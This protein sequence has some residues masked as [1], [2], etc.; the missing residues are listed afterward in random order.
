MHRTRLLAAAALLVAAVA[1]PVRAGEA[2]AAATAERFQL[3]AHSTLAAGA[4][5]S[6]RR[7]GWAG[8]AYMTHTGERVTVLVSTTYAEADAIG[9]RW[10]N[11]LSSLLHGSELALVR[12]HVAPLPEVEEFCE[13]RV[14]GCYGGN[15]LV[16]IGEPVDDVTAEEVMR[17]EYG[18]HVAANR[19]NPPWAA[20]DWG[21][22]RW[23]SAADVCLR[24]AG[25]TAFPG[26]EDLYY[27][28]NPGEAFA[29]AYRV[30]NEVRSGARGFSWSLADPSFSPDEH[31]LAA[32]E[33]DVLRPWAPSPQRIIGG[34][35]RDAARTWTH[36]IATPLDGNLELSLRMPLGSG[37]TLEL[38]DSR[39]GIVARGLWSGSGVRTLRYRICGQR[40]VRVRVGR[41]GGEPRFQVRVNVP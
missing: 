31:E 2:G 22:K 17:H 25:E 30:L 18:H 27:S 5:R 8:G 16:S 33:A 39:G 1:A 35:L 21:T 15:T 24:V 10:A 11:F 32:V 13:G 20:I 14:L 6:L 7:V 29:E 41:A 40:S 28:H 37:H 3:P 4:A 9:L 23:A 19:L 26:D 12:A 38:L 36:T 34:R